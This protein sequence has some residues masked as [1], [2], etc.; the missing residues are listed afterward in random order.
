MGPTGYV[1]P[2]GTPPWETLFSQTATRYFLDQNF[3][4]ALELALEGTVE[5]PE[6]PVHYLLAGMA[7][8]RQAPGRGRAR[9]TT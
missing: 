8:L 4:R 9:A 2:L 3:Q 6:N 5:V 1:Y 7:H